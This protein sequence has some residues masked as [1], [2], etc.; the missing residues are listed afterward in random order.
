MSFVVA[1][2]RDFFWVDRETRQR[3]KR[4]ELKDRGFITFAVLPFWY[5]W[6]GNLSLSLSLSLS[7]LSL[8]HLSLSSTS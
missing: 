8:S 2:G 4:K 7:A 6:C 5:F 1:T 3:E